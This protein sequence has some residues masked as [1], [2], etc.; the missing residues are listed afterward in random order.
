LGAA[1][2]LGLQVVVEWAEPR[3]K[4]T[5]GAAASLWFAAFSIQMLI[6]SS[7]RADPAPTWQGIRLDTWA[8][9]FF[10]VVATFFIGMF[11]LRANRL[12]YQN[13]L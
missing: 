12:K 4:T 10:L 6:L 7:L 3:L 8:A 1:S 2:I 13:Q 9:S 5:A 11:W